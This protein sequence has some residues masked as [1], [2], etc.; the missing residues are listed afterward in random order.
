MNNRLELVPIT[1]PGHVLRENI[2]I[3]VYAGYLRCVECVDRSGDTV[4]EVMESKGVLGVYCLPPMLP[5]PLPRTWKVRD[6]MVRNGDTWI[7]F[8]GRT[9]PPSEHWDKVV[10]VSDWY[11][12]TEVIDD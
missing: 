7:R 5:K 8:V 4:A 3:I 2:D 1:A 9:K 12:M 6:Y 10:P 11:T